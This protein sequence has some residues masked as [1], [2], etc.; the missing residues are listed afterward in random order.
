MP[1]SIA[2][3]IAADPKRA[4]YSKIGGDSPQ[5][6]V[7]EWAEHLADGRAEMVLLAGAEAIANT[8]AAIRKNHSPDWSEK[9]EGSLED[10]GLGLE[11]LEEQGA[12]VS[13]ASLSAFLSERRLSA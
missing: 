3:R 8:K 9:V 12:L 2:R 4:I 6:L 7:G 10:A 5:R 11:G 1:R 13:H